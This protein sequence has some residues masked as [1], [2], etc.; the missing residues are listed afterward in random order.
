MVTHTTEIDIM[1]GLR[2]VLDAQVNVV[3][4]PAHADL[5]EL[6]T[7]ADQVYA[8]MMKQRRIAMAALQKTISVHSTAFTLFRNAYKTMGGVLNPF[9]EA[10]ASMI[11]TTIIAYT[12]VATLMAAS[13]IGTM[14]AAILVAGIIGFALYTESVK[15]SGLAEMGAKMDEID[16]T[17]QSALS[18]INALKR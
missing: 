12:Q 1:V 17:M 18:F 3:T 13:V 16:A 10:M 2:E 11:E 4:A 9:G 7:H 15:A 14:G 5:D 8:E 6:A